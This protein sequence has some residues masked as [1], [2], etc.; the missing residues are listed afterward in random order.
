MPAA[1]AW[2]IAN[3]DETQPV[4][5]VRLQDA[6]RLAERR[7]RWLASCRRSRPAAQA[8]KGAGLPAPEGDPVRR[9]R[10]RVVD[11]DTA[12]RIESRYLTN[13]IVNQ[14]SKNMIQ[15]FF[16]DLQAINAGK[17]RPEG[18]EP[19]TG[20]Q[21]GR[22]RRRDDGGRHRYSAPAP[23]CRWCSR[24]SRLRPPR[25]ARPTGED[26][27]QGSPAARSTEEK[28]QAA[29]DR[30]TPTADASGPHEGATW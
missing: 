28:S 5:Q 12:S 6:R 23:G 3:P 8:A 10:R 16:F 26:D 24:T 21:G 1:K 2:I 30:I 19:Y 11:F 27:R 18:I 17:L 13:L 15:A 4:G 29:L 7:R 14:G 25:R 9:R 20:H 22:S